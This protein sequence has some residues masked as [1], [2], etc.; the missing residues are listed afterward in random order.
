[1]QSKHRLQIQKLGPVSVRETTLKA[2]PIRK[3]RSEDLR[4][5]ISKFLVSPS[6]PTIPLVGVGG[7]SSTVSCISPREFNTRKEKH[8]QRAKQLT[9]TYVIGTPFLGSWQ[10]WSAY[11]VTVT[12]PIGVC[13]PF[14][15]LTL[16]S[17]KFQTH[18]EDERRVQCTSVCPSAAFPK[19]STLP[20]LLRLCVCSTV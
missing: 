19:T 1:M 14:L 20:C 11:S 8:T 18:R 2:S 3:V 6:S 5:E 16:H 13:L 10:K 7:I 9:C 12:S 17:E 15:L 4:G